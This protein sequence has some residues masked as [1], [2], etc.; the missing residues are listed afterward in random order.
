MVGSEF[1]LPNEES[2]SSMR[3]HFHLIQEMSDFVMLFRFSCLSLIYVSRWITLI[4]LWAE[5]LRP[6]QEFGR[7]ICPC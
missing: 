4:Q 1:I 3:G 7:N 2:L 6:R 5:A